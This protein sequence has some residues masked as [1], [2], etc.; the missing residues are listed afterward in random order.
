MPADQSNDHPE[1]IGIIDGLLTRDEKRAEIGGSKPI[2]TATLY[3]GIKR[4][5]YPPPVR[6]SPG[7][8]RFP[9]GKRATPDGGAHG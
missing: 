2:S 3:R 1:F 4:G 6:I 8:V 7:L 9:R 5:I